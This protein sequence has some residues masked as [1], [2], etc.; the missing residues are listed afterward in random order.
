M[1]Y[2]VVSAAFVAAVVFAISPVPAKAML[3]SGND[4][5]RMPTMISGMADGP[6]KWEMYKHLAMINAAMAKDGLSGC[7]MAMKKMMGGTKMS[8]M[9]SGM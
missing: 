8:K 1:K 9:K 5:S 6:H 3:C 2:S 7:D 4:M